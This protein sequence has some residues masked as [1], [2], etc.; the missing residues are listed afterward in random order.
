MTGVT[1]GPTPRPLPTARR[2][3]VVLFVDDEPDILDAIK[4]LVE[5]SLEGVEVIAVETAR[6]ALDILDRER[7]DLI[8]SDCKM[9]GMDGIELLYQ[10]RRL[11]PNIPRVMLTAFASEDMARRAAV[12][13]VVDGFLSKNAEPRALLD[14]LQRLLK[15]SPSG[16]RHTQEALAGP[17]SS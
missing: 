17:A 9:P 4:N 15:Y 11:H 2:P 10:C 1:A 12:E 14:A 6:E 5:F 8:V 3:W 7:I 16:S 13:A